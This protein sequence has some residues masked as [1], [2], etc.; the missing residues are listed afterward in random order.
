MHIAERIDQLFADEPDGPAVKYEGA[1]WTWEEMQRIR[2]GI[3]ELVAG[4]GLAEGDG[5]GLVLRERPH[6]YGAYLSILNRHRCAVLVTPIQPDAAMCEDVRELHLRVLIA[7]SEDWRRVG[8]VDAARDAGTLGIELT[9]DR[10]HPVRRVEG[11]ECDL[12]GDHYVAVPNAAVTILTSGTTGRPKRVPLS[13]DA[14]KGAPPPEPR[15]PWKRGVSI[16]AVPLVSIGGA[17]GAV[18]TVWRGRPTALMDRF[19]V[20]KWAEL[21]KEHRPR[22]LGAPPATLRMLLDAKVPPEYLESGEVFSAAS[23][24]VDLATSDEFEQ[25][26][27]IPVVR[28]YGA[29]EFLGA[30]TGFGPDDREFVR[31]KRGSVGRAFVGTQIRII[32][33][34]TGDELPRGEIG[35]LEA[36]PSRRP[37]DAASGWIRT[38]DLAH[39]DEDGFVWIH[40]RADSVIIRGGFKV[41]AD[42]VAEALREHPAI[43]DAAV[44]G[45]P[46]PTLGEVPVAAVTLAPDATAPP[47]PELQDWVRT[48][49]PPYSVP[50]RI[51][52]VDD[53]P[54]NAMLKVVPSQVL[55]LIDAAG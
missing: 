51:R 11:T 48:R 46:H 49:L 15:A 37:V 2:D 30:V 35:I 7:D 17:T 16:N 27:G 6:T 8:L 26:Y 44:V 21:V 29:T 10:E 52:V 39:M 12:A 19:D 50:V 23:A 43:A 22:R 24:P 18:G 54:R 40:G 32:D 9:G 34:D 45:S 47:E 53:L 31:V 13:Y 5:V 36:D 38:N 41:Q 3:D 25:V 1:W 28:A 4:A 42:E 55:A 33:P 20:W 14:L